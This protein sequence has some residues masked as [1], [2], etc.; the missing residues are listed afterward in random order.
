[1]KRVCFLYNV[2]ILFVL[3]IIDVNQIGY[4]FIFASKSQEMKQCLVNKEVWII[5]QMLPHETNYNCNQQISKITLHAHYIKIHYMIMIG[6]QYA[7]FEIT[8]W[9]KRV[10]FFWF[11]IY[12]K[13][14]FNR[15][16]IFVLRYL[17]NKNTI[18][19]QLLHF[20]ILKV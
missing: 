4:N 9:I 16:K 13:M 12:V 7:V 19:I 2:A 6:Y 11:I 10:S 3:C 17:L 5:K 1:M 20:Y 14:N 8:S 15:V 18:Q